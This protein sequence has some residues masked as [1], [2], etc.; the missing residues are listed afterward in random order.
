[1]VFNGD[2]EVKMRI[3]NRD[4]EVKMRIEN[5]DGEVKMWTENGDG[6]VVYFSRNYCGSAT[7]FDG[8]V[9]ASPC[10]N[11]RAKQ[12]SMPQPGRCQGFGGTITQI[13]V[14]RA[15]E[16]KPLSPI[17][18]ACNREAFSISI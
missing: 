11:Y 4:G 17:Q 6:D 2:D 3:E 14:F 9:A 10:R 16:L 8:E 12:V 18:L 1:M 7:K 13:V 5:R 15:I